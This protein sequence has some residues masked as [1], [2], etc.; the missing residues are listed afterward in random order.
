M[1]C[2]NCAGGLQA[3]ATEELISQDLDGAD[4]YTHHCSTCGTYWHLHLH[5]GGVDLISTKGNQFIA[6]KSIR[7]NLLVE[8]QN[9]VSELEKIT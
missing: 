6:S 4:Y 7:D 9:R 5:G 8:L 3:V 1:F 2:P